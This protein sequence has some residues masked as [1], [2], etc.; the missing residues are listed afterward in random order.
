MIQIIYKPPNFNCLCSG[1]ASDAL[2]L[3]N[4]ES[5]TVYFVVVDR[6]GPRTDKPWNS[7][8]RTSSVPLVGTKTAAIRH[9]YLPTPFSSELEVAI[10]YLPTPN[11]PNE[12]EIV[13]K[14]RRNSLKG[15]QCIRTDS[16]SQRRPLSSGGTSSLLYQTVPP[17]YQSAV[18]LMYQGPAWDRGVGTRI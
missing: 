1:T 9:F 12:V 11:A 8:L 6:S 14:A 18:P 2:Q 7:E 15:L 13:R 3:P 4:L 17:L 5:S 16:D 10:N